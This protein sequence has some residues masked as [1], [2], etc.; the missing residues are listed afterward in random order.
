MKSLTSIFQYLSLLFLCASCHYN[1]SGE[2]RVIDAGSRKPLSDVKISVLKIDSLRTDAEGKFRFDVLL[3]TPVTRVI[4][5]NKDGYEPKLYKVE[6]YKNNLVEMKPVKGSFESAFPSEW[7]SIFYNINK[8]FISGINILTIAFILVNKRIKWRFASVLATVLF[9]ITFGLSYLDGALLE[10][11]IIG[12]PIH[13]AH[14]W[15]Y[16][17]TIMCMLPMGAILFWILYF[18]NF[19]NKQQSSFQAADLGGASI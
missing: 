9:N 8:F 11:Q 14:H 1:M 2:G 7:V 6:R 16:P 12:S 3:L 18:K 10:W 19:L 15:T 5:L 17:F 4:L 13:I